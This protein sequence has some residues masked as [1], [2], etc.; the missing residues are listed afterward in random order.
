MTNLVVTVTG[1]VMVACKKVQL[2][3]TA[4]DILSTHVFLLRSTCHDNPAQQ[5]EYDRIILRFR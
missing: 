4:R 3:K 1:S 2:K 5:R